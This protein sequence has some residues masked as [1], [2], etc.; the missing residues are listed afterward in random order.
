MYAPVVT[1]FD[2][3]SVDV[4]SGTRAY[5]ETILSLPAFREWLG[6]ALE[7]TWVVS[8]DEVDEPPVAVYRQAA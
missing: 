4:D 2:T 3:Y 5:M 1:R 6:A 7:E 8:F